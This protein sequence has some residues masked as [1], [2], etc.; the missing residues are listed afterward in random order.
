MTTADRR[1]DR[2]LCVS[3]GLPVFNGE[4]YLDRAL[5][6]LLAQDFTDFEVIICDNASTDRTAN[7][8][9]VGREGSRIRSSGTKPTIGASNNRARIRAGAPTLLPLGS[10]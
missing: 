9:R 5:G 10:P 4:A 1:N 6:S 2:P 3:I 7:R 8:R